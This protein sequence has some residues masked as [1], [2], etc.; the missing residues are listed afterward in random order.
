MS[1]YIVSDVPYIAQNTYETCWLASYKMMLAWKGKS[2]E[3]AEQLPDHRK[4]RQEGI[5]DAQL[6]GC[7][8][9]LNLSSSTYTGFRDEEAIESKLQK[10]GPIWVSGFFASGHKHIVVLYGVRGSGS[11]AQVLIN[12]PQTG[13]SITNPKPDWWSLGWFANRL[14]EVP[15]ACQHWM[16]KS[17]DA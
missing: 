11:K 5:M 1:E 4:M 8:K 16:G 10:Y 12:D 9:A 14:N 3:L 6:L 17:G 13:M 2:K 15:Y 7:R